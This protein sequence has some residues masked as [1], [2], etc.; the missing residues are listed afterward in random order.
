MHIPFWVVVKVES[1][2]PVCVEAYAE[3]ESA[4]LREHWLRERMNPENDE[5]EVF[6][7]THV[8]G[9]H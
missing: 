3:A 9:A 8:S 2:I 5:S 4:H 1:G 7:I 6:Q